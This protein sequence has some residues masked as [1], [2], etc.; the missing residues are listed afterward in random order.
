[1]TTENSAVTAEVS[2]ASVEAS[3]LETIKQTWLRLRSGKVTLPVVTTITDCV[4]AEITDKE[5]QQNQQYFTVRINEM[6]LE[7]NREWWATFDPLVVVVVDFN[8]GHESITVPRIIGPELIK[9]RSSDDRARHGT[10]LLDT[11][12][13]GPHPYKGGDITIS[14]AFYRIK[15]ADHPARLLK[16][17]DSL[18]SAVGR[19]SEIQTVT[20]IGGAL[21]TGL[22]GLLELD[23]T[24]YI[25]GH[26]ISMSG[27]ALDP[28]RAGF[29]ALI[30]PPI[31]D[32]SELLV[33]DRRL[34][35][36]SNVGDKPYHGSD[37]VLWSIT[38]EDERGDENL[39]F[40]SLK[41]EALAAISEGED[42]IRRGKGNLI[43]AYQQM[44]RSHDVTA[45]EAARLLDKWCDEFEEEKK[46]VGRLHAM[47]SQVPKQSSA[48]DP[49]STDLVAAVR[50][51]GL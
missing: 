21:L 24:T 20:K 23:E 22:E 40:Y 49:A 31:P 16:V 35:L 32:I 37:F 15:R 33:R 17:V 43:S 12:V 3:L 18:S 11:R 47:P 4:P 2:A 8:Y 30:T 5:I 19:P 14:V 28:L 38:G 44:R 27:S 50:R 7:E 46:R 25:A 26:R 51:I 6:H 45:K 42:G 13:T 29:S 9:Q 1:M 41:E 36:K 39:P 48:S 10:V 34:R